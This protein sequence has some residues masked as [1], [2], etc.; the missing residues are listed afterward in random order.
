MQQTVFGIGFDPLDLRFADQ[1]HAAIVTH[2]KATATGFGFVACDCRRRH[3][4]D[5]LI[6]GIEQAAHAQIECTRQAIVDAITCTLQRQLQAFTTERLDQKVDC[7]NR[8]RIDRALTAGRGVNAGDAT[9]ERALSDLQAI[10]PGNRDIEQG[11]IHRISGQ[12][13]QGAVTIAARRHQLQL[14]HRRDQTLQPL[15]RQ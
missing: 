4:V 8:E 14:R 9:L 12:R 13:L 1:A 5:A 6:A 11:D 3:F 10:G 7:F 2:Q 15:P